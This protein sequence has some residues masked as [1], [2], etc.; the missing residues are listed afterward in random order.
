M[1]NFRN[2]AQLNASR[3]GKAALRRAGVTVVAT[4]ASIVWAWISVLV[5]FSDLESANSIVNSDVYFKTVSALVPIGLFCVI[6]VLY[7]SLATIKSELFALQS[8]MARLRSGKIDET[9]YPT[10][11]FDPE[12][13]IEKESPNFEKITPL[14][15]LEDYI[16]DNLEISEPEVKPP[17]PAEFSGLTTWTLI[18]A[19]HFAD[20]E[21]DREH[22]EAVEAALNNE[23]AADLLQS[24]YSVL[25]YLAERGI[26]AD[27]LATSFSKHEVWRDHAE[28]G[29]INQI[30]VLGQ[31]GSD[32][33]VE[34]V[35]TLAV[36]DL[37][38]K[39]FAFDFLALV[40]SFLKSFIPS[41][42]DYEI[43]ALGETRTIRAYV[44]L[45]NAADGN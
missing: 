40:H 45:G 26:D 43:A 19:L 12:A 4:V 35:A 16:E 41:T 11:E 23:K 2:F 37:D 31:V 27:K 18:Q 22:V 15:D 29:N 38:F 21:N 17:L 5:I 42:E 25:E 28:S 24:A 8:E 1:R 32:Q 3:S 10:E 6:A 34:S 9:Y 13:E 7:N 20:D 33:D 39:K 14:P 44:L 30:G 36:S